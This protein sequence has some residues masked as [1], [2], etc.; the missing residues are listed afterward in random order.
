MALQDGRYRDREW[1][2]N[3]RKWPP[4]LVNA[5]EGFLDVKAVARS[6]IRRTFRLRRSKSLQDYLVCGLWMHFIPHMQ[7]VKQG[8]II[9]A[10][11]HLLCFLFLLP[12]LYDPSGGWFY[13]RGDN[14]THSYQSW[15]QALFWFEI[16]CAHW[17]SS[18]KIKY[19][20][21]STPAN[22]KLVP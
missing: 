20:K 17:T 21:L 18:Y 1:V 16:L 12:F 5:L 2:R 4:K 13:S 7:V 15:A 10:S 8:L 19:K 9:L 11:W 3:T 6:W 14:T 22:A